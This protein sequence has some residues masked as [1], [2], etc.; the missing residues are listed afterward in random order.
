[1]SRKS[2]V[3]LV[4][5]ALT[6]ASCVPPVG[7]QPV[8]SPRIPVDA[9]IAPNTVLVRYLPGSS[10]EQRALATDVANG[11]VAETY[12]LVPGLEKLIVPD[13]QAALKSLD[14]LSYVDYAEPDYH[15]DLADTTPNDPLYPQLWGMQ[16]VGAPA[17]WDSATGNPAVIV[18][19]IDT[20]VDYTHPDLAANIWANTD[21]IAGNGI[22]DDHNGYV[23]DIR[24]WDFYDGDNDPMGDWY[25][26]THV[27]GTIGAAGNNGVGV[28]GINWRVS[29]MPLRFMSA[30][31]GF[32]SGAISGAAICCGQWRTSFQ[33]QLWLSILVLGVERRDPVSRRAWP[34]CDSCCR[35]QRPRQRPDSLLSGVV[36]I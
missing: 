22:D 29:L 10:K 4:V 6:I 21:E 5:L 17:A 20:G 23:D 18:A 15:L 12:T 32:T 26:G 30:E 14:Q 11:K 25:H 13:V 2:A 34:S 9:A 16:N 36:R 7:P 33:S 27:A 19:V 31:G 3:L 24:G 1:M 28:T 8:P 35:Q